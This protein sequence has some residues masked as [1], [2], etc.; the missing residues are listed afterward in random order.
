LPKN[1]QYKI[2][3]QFLTYFSLPIFLFFLYSGLKSGGQPNW[4]APAYF[5]VSAALGRIWSEALNK[6]H[7][8][9]IRWFN[10]ALIYSGVLSVIFYII[11]YSPHLTLPIPNNRIINEFLGWSDLANQTKDYIQSQDIEKIFVPSY[12]IASLLAFYGIDQKLI[13]VVSRRQT[14]YHLWAKPREEPE[15]NA[16]YITNHESAID[17]NIL[18]QYQSID[19]LPVWHIQ[20]QGKPIRKMDVIKLRNGQTN[21]LESETAINWDKPKIGI[22]IPTYNE[23]DNLLSILEEL[24]VYLPDA[25]ILIVDDSSPDGT[26]KLADQEAAK[27]ACI[28][29][30]HRSN[31]RGLGSAYIEG[32]QNMLQKGCQVIVQMDC[33]FSHHPAAVPQLIKGLA[34]ADVVVGSRYML[35]GRA[36]CRGY[37]RELIS[38][39]GSTYAATM[40]DLPYSDLTSG[41]KAWRASALKSL[42][43]NQILSKGFVFQIE[44]TYRCHRAGLQIT[45]IPIQFH[46]RRQGYS[47]LNLSIILEALYVC[48]C[49]WLS[50][51]ETTRS[52]KVN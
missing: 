43:S 18:N 38:R 2:A 14:Q 13:E 4:P 27:N 35:G 29:V 19:R 40:L 25:S 42:L 51:S 9:L 6:R 17:E 23:K 46:D 50:Q 37:I 7:S 48:G 26:G 39:L 3:E 24:R 10:G 12:Q 31:K 5:A 47:K 44:M 30:L 49:I 16:I 21:H 11:V 20:S 32:F 45:E 22:V 28:E 1:D 52:V 15:K 36:F 41:F 34:S 8:S 33:D